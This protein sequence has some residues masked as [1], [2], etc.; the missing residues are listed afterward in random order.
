MQTAPPKGRGDNNTEIE[1]NNLQFGS[2]VCA[3][4]PQQ[5]RDV[6]PGHILI[7]A[8]GRVD[9][10]P[11]GCGVP[12]MLVAARDHGA[13]IDV[14]AVA[15]SS[16]ELSYSLR[17]AAEILGYEDLDRA[18]AT[19]EV[20]TLHSTV[21]RWLDGGRRGCVIVHWACAISLLSRLKAIVCDTPALA[22]TLSEQLERRGGR[23]PDITV[24]RR[25]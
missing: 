16:P 15:S 10:A 25:R 24:R 23:M 1:T 3:S 22:E 5:I 20:L 4:S 19:G 8:Y 7:D 13:P 11:P 18:Y 14:I 6:W 17:G 21:R 12:A 2:R 9:L